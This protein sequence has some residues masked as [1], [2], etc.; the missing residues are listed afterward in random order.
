MRLSRLSVK[1]QVL[2]LGRLQAAPA[3][4]ACNTRFPRLLVILYLRTS[5]SKTRVQVASV[6]QEDLQGAAVGAAHLVDAAFAFELRVVGDPVPAA[7]AVQMSTLS[8]SSSLGTSSRSLQ[9]CTASSTSAATLSGGSAA[10]ADRTPH[11]QCRESLS[12]GRCRDAGGQNSLPIG[13]RRFVRTL[14]PRAARA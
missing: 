4:M 13:L 9:E 2:S 6:P 3:S 8:T 1:L 5:C 7:V 10:R 12:S 14:A 11:E